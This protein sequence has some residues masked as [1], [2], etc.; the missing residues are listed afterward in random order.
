MKTFRKKLNENKE[1][2]KIMHSRSVHIFVR[3]QGNSNSDGRRQIQFLYVF[4]NEY[5]LMM[6]GKFNRS[7]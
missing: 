1:M 6:F 2:R 3:G 5:K 4:L 7:F